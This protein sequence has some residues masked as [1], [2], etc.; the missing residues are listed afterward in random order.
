M[1]YTMVVMSTH[2]PESENRQTEHV[3]GWPIE[4]YARVIKWPAVATF[5][6]NVIVITAEWSVAVM[7]FFV[8]LLTVALGILVAR[9]EKG[10][11]GNAVVTGVAAGLVVG[12]MSSLFQFLWIRT[13]E[14][15]FQIVTTSLLAM[16]VGALMTTSAFLVLAKEHR[17][18]ER[19]KKADHRRSRHGSS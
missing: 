6:L 8:T 16:M 15:F 3:S 18:S 7:W 2:R 17:P 19:L 1:W 4:R 13:V 14:S 10:N 12:A 9:I 5:V 11:L